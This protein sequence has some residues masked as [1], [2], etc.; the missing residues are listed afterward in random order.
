LG[1]QSGSLQQVI[2]DYVATATGKYY[3]KISGTGSDYS[4]VV[5]VNATFDIGRND[6][7]AT[8]QPIISPEIGGSRTVLGYV[9][10]ESK[11]L[12][13]VDSGWWNSGGYHDATNDNYLTGQAYG[14][15]YRNYVVFDLA[16]VEG[17]IVGATLK[18]FNPSGG[19]VSLDDSETFSL[20]DVSTPVPLLT[21]SGFG[22]LGIF[23]DL[24]SGVAFGSQAVSMSDDGRVVSITLNAAGLQALSAA[25]GGQVALGGALTSLSGADLE[26]VFA[27]SGNPA[28]I[29]QLALDVAESDFYKIKGIAN[30]TIEIVTSTPGS[31]SGEFVN[32]LNPY[33]KL[34]DAAG[35][36][37][38]SNESG[39][40]GL[41]AKLKY[42][43]AKGQE[44]GPFFIQVGAEGST[45]GEY[46][47][48]IKGAES[49]VDSFSVDSTLPASG[50]VLHDPPANFNVNFN[51]QFNFATLQGSDL[52]VD[53]IGGSTVSIVDGDTAN[54]VTPYVYSSGGH[55]YTLTS[56]AK[57]WADAEAEAIAKGGH[58]VTINSA[59]EQ[60]FLKN[61]FAS[62]AHRYDYYWTGFNDIASEG[63]FVW[64]S[65]QP[66]TYT[67][68]GPN[69]PNE[70]P[71]GEDAV[72]MNWYRGLNEPYNGAWNDFNTDQQVFGIIE[73]N[74]RP[75]GS[76]LA[77]EGTHTVKL[78]AGSVKDLQGTDLTAYSG[79][80][81]LD[82][83]PPRVVASSIAN[84]SVLPAGDLTYIVTFSE[85]LQT[86]LVDL[87]DIGLFGTYSGTF[88][89]PTNLSFDTSGKVL[90]VNFANLA[91]DV[92]TLTLYAHE[93]SFVD[94][95]GLVLD[96]EPPV[97]SGNGIEGGDYFVS[98]ATDSGTQ[99]LTLVPVEPLGSLVYTTP[100]DALGLIAFAGDTDDFTISIDPGQRLT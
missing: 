1:L 90:T 82:Y 92:Y 49:V 2:D 3:V 61:V 100:A 11:T 17:N 75:A 81:T 21:S 76:W 5:T 8:A 22:E 80:F 73:L 95:V 53:N 31:K 58:L 50:T 56:S 45:K 77:T 60:T 24:G 20:F 74:A 27:Y 39:G 23:D 9:G 15:Q 35:N 64:A 19:Y 94:Q 34:Y 62:D 65:G 16:G 18:L 91:D 83:T 79:S 70:Y 78:A 84:N 32:T 57:N 14:E 52:K 42:K 29:R 89:N 68:W 63:T 67:N 99:A 41:N 72:V 44:A 33:L 40:S 69:E 85:S 93:Y 6:S 59:A 86:G 47:L 4:L 87:S 28:E 88:Q 26:L 71:P 37:L 54:F 12:D 25:A 96:G 97:V 30:K 55:Y 98:F 38:A 48:S 10:S 7:I 36:L 43:P 51:D 46:T 13:Y 66:V